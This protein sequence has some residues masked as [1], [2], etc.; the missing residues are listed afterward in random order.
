MFADPSGAVFCV[1]Q[2]KEHKGAQLVNEPDARELGQ[3]AAR[4]ELGVGWR[5]VY[6]YLQELQADLQ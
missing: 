4:R 3:E 1:W 2:A 5:T 6:T